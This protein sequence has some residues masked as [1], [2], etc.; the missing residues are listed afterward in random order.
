MS[1]NQ[2]LP[3]EPQAGECIPEHDSFNLALSIFILIGMFVSYLPQVS[4]PFELLGR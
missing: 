2:L 1:F 4:A 3:K